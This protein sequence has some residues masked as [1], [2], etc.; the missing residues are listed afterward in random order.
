MATIKASHGKGASKSSSKRRLEH[1]H[2]RR[3]GNGF[4][5]HKE[6]AP[7]R[8]A[9]GMRMPTPDEPPA[10]FTKHAQAKKHIAAA[11]DEMHPPGQADMNAAGGAGGSD[12]DADQDQ[13][14]VA[15]NP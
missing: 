5:V 4:M 11:M 2:I 14:P 6:Y 13:A 9:D 1:I 8:D 15:T 10:V 7:E 12:L 3:A